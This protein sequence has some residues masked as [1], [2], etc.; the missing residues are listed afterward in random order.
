M[1]QSLPFPRRQAYQYPYPFV[2]MARATR[3]IFRTSLR[4]SFVGLVVAACVL[5]LSSCT[6]WNTSGSKDWTLPQP[7]MSPDSVVLEIATLRIPASESGDPAWWADVDEQL[8]SNEQRKS[9]DENGFRCGLI[10]GELPVGLQQALGSQR[11]T[12][13]AIDGDGEASSP[14]LGEQR[15]Q[16]RTG[17]R[18]KIVTT[19]IRDN[20]VVLVPR[21]NQ[22][23]GRTLSQAQCIINVRSFPQGDGS[24]ELEITP[25]IEH[26]EA[27][28]R[29]VGQAHEGAF[30]IDTNRNRLT[31]DGLQLRP[32]LSPGQA[33]VLCATADG[34]GIGHQFFADSENG[35]TERRVL[36]IR[37]AQSQ[38][39]DLF[40]EGGTQS[41]LATP[42][43]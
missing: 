41:P 4:P 43:E 29:W 26:G 24:V 5:V 32:K 13:S 23:T 19:A 31:L 3:L 17:R 8:I 34:K 7:R 21:E 12:L 35:S 10:R 22:L 20:L 9:L 25:E 38:L 18:S 36:L 11:A 42:I 6:S 15:L 1:P 39:D 27:K 14:T 40:S 16:M 33:L 30:R 2:H 28:Q 37:L